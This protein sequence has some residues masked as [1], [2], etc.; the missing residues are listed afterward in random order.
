[1]WNKLYAVVN[2]YVD[3]SK[4]REQTIH[5]QVRAPSLALSFFRVS[6]II[7]PTGTTVF[8]SCIISL[9]PITLVL[10]LLDLHFLWYHS[11]MIVVLITL[12]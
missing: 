2:R 8:S 3:L 7:I 5:S 6:I 4:L 9:V 10:S 1:M 12:A 11:Y